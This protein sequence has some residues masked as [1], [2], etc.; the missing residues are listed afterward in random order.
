MS[1][2]EE[3]CCS[4]GLDT[5]LE[6]E[7]ESIDWVGAYT[8]LRYE[9]LKIDCILSIPQSDCLLMHFQEHDLYACTETDM[10]NHC[11]MYDIRPARALLFARYCFSVLKRD[12][13]LAQHEGTDLDE[14]TC[15]SSNPTNILPNQVQSMQL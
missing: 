12:P 8:T 6:S 9:S 10:V 2:L 14:G 3:M 11:S 15:C 13:G 4:S 1:E 5:I 7:E